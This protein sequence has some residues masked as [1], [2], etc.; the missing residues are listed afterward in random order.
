MSSS[1]AD[2]FYLLAMPD[3]YIDTASVKNLKYWVL[4]LNKF[5]CSNFRNASEHENVK[6]AAAKQKLMLEQLETIELYELYPTS[7]HHANSRTVP[8][9]HP[10]PVT[11]KLTSDE[12]TVNANDDGTEDRRS[13][14]LLATSGKFESAT[15]D[16][17]VTSSDSRPFSMEHGC[18]I[19][20]SLTFAER[21]TEISVH[22]Q[23][24]PDS[25]I[26]NK[27]D[28]LHGR[29]RYW[30]STRKPLQAPD[31]QT[32][33]PV[34]LVADSSSGAPIVENDA[35][36]RSSLHGTS[37]QARKS[38]YS[39]S[40]PP[41]RDKILAKSTKSSRQDFSPHGKSRDSDSETGSTAAVSSST[42]TDVRRFSYSA[43]TKSAKLSRWMD[44]NSSFRFLKLRHEEIN[45]T[46]LAEKAEF[47]LINN[48]DGY[49][50]LACAQRENLCI[51]GI[52]DVLHGSQHS[53]KWLFS[54]T[55]VCPDLLQ[56]VKDDKSLQ[57]LHR[58]LVTRLLH[59]LRQAIRYKPD[60]S[61]TMHFMLGK[62]NRQRLELLPSPAKIA[63]HAADLDLEIQLE[64]QHRVRPLKPGDQVDFHPP[65]FT[66]RTYPEAPDLL[67]K[68]WRAARIYKSS[69]SV[70]AL[71]LSLQ[72][73]QP[74][75]STPTAST[76]LP[77]KA[78]TTRRSSSVNLD[79]RSTSLGPN[80]ALIDLFSKIEQHQMLKSLQGFAKRQQAFSRLA[81][82][83]VQSTC[84]L[85]GPAACTDSSQKRRVK[86]FYPTRL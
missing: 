7:F 37:F 53:P 18:S 48:A 40:P 84:S 1:S 67:P 77:V 13:K 72:K 42:R 65:D 73:N 21:S 85:I 51:L 3:C 57:V 34:R 6:I 63:F 26:L 70:I 69:G 71:Q 52:I 86:F 28:D 39:T 32:G 20:S 27:N 4:E 47:R 68:L 50:K 24:A 31:Q 44:D 54:P 16:Y 61:S 25:E 22:R 45:R 46:L 23:K 8:S 29:S 14:N 38:T 33:L 56:Y 62:T 12:S 43:L 2:L 35:K 19:P 30:N 74:T 78:A 55:C 60:V 64:K 82:N 36:R 79:H 5:M 76:S 81:E 59:N 83:V 9:S 75:A 41:E 15:S 80:P 49:L 11:F 10:Q 17:D 58:K 66:S